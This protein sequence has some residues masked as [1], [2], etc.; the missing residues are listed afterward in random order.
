MPELVID[1]ELITSHGAL[2]VYHASIDELNRR[3]GGSDED[4]HLHV[5][6]LMAP[7]GA[8][9]VA[10]LDGHPVGGVGLRPISDPAL[11]IG[12]IKRLWV[13][14]DQRRCGVGL[15]SC[16]ESK[17][18]H[19]RLGYDSSTSNRVTRNPK[20][21]SSIAR[22]AGTRSRSIRREHTRTRSPTAL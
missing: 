14:P 3:Y 19:A 22:R 1:D 6:E 15:R 5:E 7:L 9:L 4:R 8:F 18:A 11:H 16:N 12:E 17:S 13:R 20:R 10:R 21:W 2:S